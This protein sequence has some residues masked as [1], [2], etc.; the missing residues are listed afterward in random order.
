M[1]VPFSPERVDAGNKIYK[2]KNTPKVNGGATP[3]SP[4]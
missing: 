3:F 2:T 4:G 1:F